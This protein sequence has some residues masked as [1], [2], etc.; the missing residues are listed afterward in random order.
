MSDKAIVQTDL[1]TLTAMSTEYQE[2]TSRTSVQMAKKKEMQGK[3]QSLKAKMGDIDRATSTYEKEFIDRKQAAPLSYGRIQTLQDVVLTSF[4]LSYFLLSLAIIVYVWRT[5]P[6]YALM[7][8]GT[9]A[10]VMTVLGIVVAELVRRY[11]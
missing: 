3:I 11:A 9:T 10:F 7:S 4:L 5:T 6:S 1:A 2:I 8:A